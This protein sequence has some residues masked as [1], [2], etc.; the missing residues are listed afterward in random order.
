MRQ[1]WI[2]DAV[3][4]SARALTDGPG[5]KSLPRFM[6]DG[7]H[8][9]HVVNDTGTPSGWQVAR[10]SRDGSEVRRLTDDDHW[11]FYPAP[12]PDGASI[13]FVT[14]RGGMHDPAKLWLM[15]ADGANPRPLFD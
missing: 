8:V 14:I 3:G 7:R 1:I 5:R 15:D 10:V 12:S 11:K 4:G 13:V 9:L 6:P 2:L